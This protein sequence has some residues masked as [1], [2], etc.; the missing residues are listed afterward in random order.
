MQKGEKRSQN[1]APPHCPVRPAHAWSPL[2][3]QPHREM[4][5]QID[6][7][8]EPA[9]GT[10]ALAYGDLNV[11]TATYQFQVLLR[12]RA[13]ACSGGRTRRRGHKREIVAPLTHRPAPLTCPPRSA[14]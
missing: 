3:T 11:T 2:L 7:L 10:S 14:I 4:A 9:P 1:P 8:H 12:V 13:R 6:A 5:K